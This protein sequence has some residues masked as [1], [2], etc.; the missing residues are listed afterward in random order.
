MIGNNS[1]GNNRDN[2]LS[3]DANDYIALDDSQIPLNITI[4]NLG[5]DEIAKCESVVGSTLGQI[6]EKLSEHG[7]NIGQSRLQMTRIQDS[8]KEIGFY[9]IEPAEQDADADVDV[10]DAEPVELVVEDCFEFTDEQKRSLLTEGFFNFAKHEDTL[11]S[12]DENGLIPLP[13]YE[14][15]TSWEQD[16]TNQ[17]EQ[18]SLLSFK[19]ALEILFA[20]ATVFLAVSLIASYLEASKNFSELREGCPVGVDDIIWTP[21]QQEK[22]QQSIHKTQK[23]YDEGRISSFWAC[24]YRYSDCNPEDIARHVSSEMGIPR[25]YSGT[26][27]TD[28]Q[29]KTC[30]DM[31]NEN[32]NRLFL[33]AGSIL[34]PTFLVLPFISV[35]LK[36]CKDMKS[37][38]ER[39]H[40]FWSSPSKG[41]LDTPLLLDEQSDDDDNDNDNDP[42]NAV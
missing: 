40:L 7:I 22:L 3:V 21:K 17:K 23:E 8:P 10:E 16:L 36:S 4:E 41:G 38:S 20:G 12:L 5:G 31:N 37:V 6:Y 13:T 11:Q 9:L 35:I 1:K 29:Y 19:L 27:V 24:G 33:L 14:D 34:V 30:K 42:A 32:E 26:Q 15:L 2:G 39:S 28:E 18:L 25:P